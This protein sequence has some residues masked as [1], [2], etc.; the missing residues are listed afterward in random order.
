L[1]LLQEIESRGD[2]VEPEIRTAVAELLRKI[3]PL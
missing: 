1:N 3:R 2:S